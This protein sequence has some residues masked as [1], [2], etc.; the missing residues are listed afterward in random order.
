MKIHD[1]AGINNLHGMPGI[2]AAI[3]GAVM[4]ALATEKNFG[5]R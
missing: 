1:P 3:A 4:A 5:Y 2:L